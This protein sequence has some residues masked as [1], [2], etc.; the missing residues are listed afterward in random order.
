M[1]FGVG[2]FLAGNAAGNPDAAEAEVLDRMLDLLRGEVGMLDG[3]GRK[4]DKAVGMTGTELRQRLVVEA[5]QLGRGIALGAVP[6][7]VDAERLD[8]DAGAVHLGEP[9]AD[10]RPQEPRRLERMVDYLR[11]VGNDAMRVDIDGL[12]PL[13][14]DHDL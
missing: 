1:E 10:I 3:S 14:V 9:V 8:I 2:Q 5:D 11:G 4:G 7:G 6:E 12:D 13:A